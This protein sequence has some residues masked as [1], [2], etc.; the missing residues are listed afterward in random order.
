MVNGA[1]SDFF[2]LI[3][4]SVLQGSILGPLLF[5]IFT[6]D[7]NLS[8]SLVNY[9]FADDIHDLVLYINRELQKIGTWLRSNKLAINANKTKIMAFHLK[10]K[11]IPELFIEF[12]FNNK[13][14]GVPENPDLIYPF[15]RIKNDSACPAYKVLGIYIDE[16][17][18]FNC[19][20]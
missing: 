3:N 12:V 2:A 17:F 8:N 10:C 15:E 9:H 14:C 4:I 1:I 11:H 18:T 7:M 13:D 6:N 20:F 19:Q 5:L 16:N